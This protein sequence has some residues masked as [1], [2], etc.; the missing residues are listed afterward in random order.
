MN[1]WEGSPAASP[2]ALFPFLAARQ[3]RTAKTMGTDGQSTLNSSETRDQSGVRARL[4]GEENRD[5]R[6]TGGDAFQVKICREHAS[7]E[8]NEGDHHDERP[9]VFEA[10]G[11]DEMARIVANRS[12]SSGRAHHFIYRA[13]PANKHEIS[14]PAFT[15]QDKKDDAAA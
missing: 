13:R 8:K 15:P 2:G 7:H 11:D 3:S 14:D 12:A 10:N 5:L 1:W 6:S 4:L 9:D